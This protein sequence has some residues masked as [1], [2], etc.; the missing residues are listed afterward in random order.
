MDTIKDW[1]DNCPLVG[2]RRQ[3]DNDSD[4]PPAIADAGVPPQ[5]GNLT[6]PLRLYPATPYQSGNA[7]DTDIPAD[8]GG[9][10]CDVDDDNDGVYDKRAP[11]HPG[12][13][14]CR[15][16]PNPDQADGDRDEKGDLC[17]K[18][19]SASATAVAEVTVPKRLA[20]RRFSEILAG[21]IVPVSCSAACSLS[22]ELARGA[23]SIGRGTAYLSGGG[24]TFLIVRLP[25]K[26]LR[27][28]D[29]KFH[30]FSAVLRVVTTSE[31]PNRVVAIRRIRLSR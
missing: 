10:A 14:N 29:R 27:N 7:L 24:T 25:R 8:K 19:F 31:T 18:E 20:P 6:G 11:G 12:P 2:N 22:A 9:D 15:D 23:S 17:D 26:S 30:H 3:Q 4:T 16:M 5:G 28:F 21:L 13:D 1:A